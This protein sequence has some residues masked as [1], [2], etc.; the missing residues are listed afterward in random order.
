MEKKSYNIGIY[1][2][3]NQVVANYEVDAHNIEEAR[4]LAWDLFIR[5]SYAEEID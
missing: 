2:L 1:A 4:E 5:D 3:G